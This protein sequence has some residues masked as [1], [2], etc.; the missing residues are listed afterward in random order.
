[1][2]CPSLGYLHHLKSPARNAKQD[3]ISKI[4]RFMPGMVAH[5]VIPALWRL[6]QEGLEFEAS[7]GYRD[8]AFYKKN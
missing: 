8:I 1:M 7:L 3:N 5:S 4:L 6:K 2:F